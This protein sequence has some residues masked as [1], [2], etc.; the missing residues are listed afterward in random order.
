M[1][2]RSDDQA[3]G[4]YLDRSLS[5]LRS[6]KPAE[7]WWSVVDRGDR[8]EPRSQRFEL[9]RND[10]RIYRCGH[11]DDVVPML[12]WW[13]N[14]VACFET[15]HRLMV[16]AAVAARHG[17]AILMP[18]AQEAGKTTLVA[19]LVADGFD[20]LTDEAAALDPES[21]MVEAFPKWLSLK[22]GSWHLF[23]HLRPDPPHDLEGVVASQWHVCPEALRP[24]AVVDT[25]EPAWIIVPV[26][27]AEAT[28]VLTPMNR[29]DALAQL[30]QQT[31]N[32][33]QLGR[34]GFE[35]LVRVV[36]RSDC[37]L[38]TSGTLPEAVAA[39]RSVTF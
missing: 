5:S 23:P 29:T 12:L 13:V 36:R 8:H 27:R 28:T 6:S 10:D 22:S 4:G 33:R 16:H 7:E 11:R 37:W 25:A 1:A 21:G 2:I 17:R 35:T 14:R 30:V 39:V 3:I 18:A 34:A 26:Y 32:L 15:S 20:Y 19:A 24:G 31:F 9:Y 38:L